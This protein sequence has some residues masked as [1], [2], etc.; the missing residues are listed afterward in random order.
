[1]LVTR[2]S[3][4]LY[5]VVNE[6]TRSVTRSFWASAVANVGLIS[7]MRTGI[8]CIAGSCSSAWRTV[9]A[10]TSFRRTTRRSG[11]R[12][13]SRRRTARCGA[14]A[15]RPRT[16]GAARPG[17]PAG[18][19][20]AA[21]RR[22]RARTPA[23]SRAPACGSGIRGRAAPPRAA[24]RAASWR[25]HRALGRRV[26]GGRLHAPQGQLEPAVE[27]RQ[28]PQRREHRGRSTR[29]PPL[30]RTIR[31]A[32]FDDTFTPACTGGTSTAFR[33]GCRARAR[34]ASSRR[35]RRSRSRDEATPR[36]SRTRS[37]NP[38][39]RAR[40]SASAVS[41]AIFMLAAATP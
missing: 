1:M 7:A 41:G 28:L 3:P 13:R 5:G 29:M 31:S 36:R 27:P 40:R 30:P 38:T 24:S 35:K 17:S 37:R 25:R 11:C 26:V 16:A 19:A 15:P 33:A 6:P 39:S 32:P 20:S 12:R 14:A 9:S 8:C 10:S 34:A 4:G 22:P 18:S 2:G 21:P 23:P